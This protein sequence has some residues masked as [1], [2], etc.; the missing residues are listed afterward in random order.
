[1]K[2]LIAAAFAAVLLM[3][4]Q[5]A[6]AG[7][8]P[9]KMKEIDAALSSNTSLSAADRGKVAGLRA[10]GEALHKAGKHGESVDAL[11]EAMKILGIN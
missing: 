11:V 5:P 1:M 3:A 4:S 9:L 6:F 2:K 8:C 10:K 7:S